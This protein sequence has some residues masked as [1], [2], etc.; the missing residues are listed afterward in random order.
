MT[1]SRRDFLGAGAAAVAGLALPNIAATLPSSVTSA[2]TVKAPFPNSPAAF[3]VSSSASTRQNRISNA[4]ARVR[5]ARDLFG[6]NI[7]FRLGQ[8]NLMY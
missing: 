2:E 5:N 7:D 6:A 3:T 4:L 8:G 1:V